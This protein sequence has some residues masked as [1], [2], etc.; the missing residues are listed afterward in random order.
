MST[1]LHEG[2]RLKDLP[3]PNVLPL[4]GISLDEKHIPYII[5]PYMA[6][7]SLKEFLCSNKGLVSL[8]GF[9]YRSDYYKLK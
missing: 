4:I 7:G 6:G 5:I 9:L 1:F 8:H 3:H 2:T